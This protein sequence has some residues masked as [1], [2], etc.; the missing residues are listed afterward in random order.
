[1]LCFFLT[2]LHVSTYFIYFWLYPSNA[3]GGTVR[4]WDITRL[5]GDMGWH[6]IQP[7]PPRFP[8][9]GTKH[10]ALPIKIM[11]HLQQGAKHD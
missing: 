7:Q 10:G 9:A 1:M 3:C 5:P 6:N 11:L 4:Y 2:G 8:W